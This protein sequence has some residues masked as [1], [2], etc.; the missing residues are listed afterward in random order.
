[1]INGNIPEG[2]TFDDVLLLP[3]RSAVLPTEVD[4]RTCLT[5][6]LAINIPLLAAAMDTV[7]ESRL[8]IAL[9]RQGGV[10]FIHRN[11]P[12]ARQAEE[13]DRV[14][15]SES[16]MIV[17]PVTV[18]PEVP[19]RHAL[20][21]MTKYR[22]SGLPVTRGPKLVGILTNR[23]LR[24]EKNVDQPVSAVMTKDHL[25]TV[26]VGTTLEDAEKMLQTHRIEKLLVVDENFNL[27]GLITVKDIQKK[28]EFP[29]AAKDEHGRLR[30]GAAV[31]ATGDFLERAVELARVKVDVLAIDTAHGHST[32]VMDAIRAVKQ[33][34]PE[35]QLIAGNVGTAEGAKELISLGVDAIKVGIGPGSICTTRVVTGAGVPQL[36]AIQS[37]ARA[38]QGSGVP[39]ISDGGVKFSGD[40]TKAIAAGAH[41]VMI[42]SLFA[43]TEE[44][45]GETILYQGRTFKSYRGMGSLGAMEAGSADRYAQD[46]ASRGKAVPEGIEGRVAFKGALG[47]MVEQ[48][49][50]GLRS[51]MGYCGVASIKELQERAQFI[52]ITSA[53]LRESHV[54][55]VSITREAPNYRLE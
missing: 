44:S 14:K 35:M 27:K 52:R 4:T 30:V 21:I 2:L 9:A 39:V 47:P 12:I 40:I 38:A 3:G 55:D 43:G 8:A 36:T 15:R 41:T 48:L 24:F 54:H 6:R 11:M 22:V 18:A 53:G 45:P 25:V 13:V 37:A 5:R 42:G 16:G 19:V 23:D 1:M 50:G 26:P 17:D 10:A 7:T 51:G 31:G 20:E 33:R 29:S 46:T 34:L 32:R 28:M 49:V